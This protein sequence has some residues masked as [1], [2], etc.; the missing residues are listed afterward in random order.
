MP[1]VDL[2]FYDLK[3]IDS[4]RHREYTGVPN[5][6]ILEN[7]EKLSR[8]HDQVVVRIPVVPGVNDDRQ[9]IGEMGD[10]LTENT[11]VK[12]VELL[13]F[14]R[15]GTGKYTGLGREYRMGQTGN[16]SKEE[17][18]PFAEEFRERGLAVKVGAE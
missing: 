9:T 16:M 2:F 7:L 11:A 10:Y 8:L 15:L 4:R 1:L 5:G 3:H 13:P 18:E 6:L 12:R 14:H 17:C